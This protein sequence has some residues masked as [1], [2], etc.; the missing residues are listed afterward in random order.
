MLLVCITVATA[1]L[2]HWNSA[3]FISMLVISI[4]ILVALPVY[5]RSLAPKPF[6]TLSIMADRSALGATLA[7]SGQHMSYG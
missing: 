7:I 2:I 6:V 5:E 1:G 3:A 4:A